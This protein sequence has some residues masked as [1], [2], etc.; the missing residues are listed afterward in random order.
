MRESHP[1]IAFHWK[2]DS[3]VIRIVG[4]SEE[5]GKLRLGAI[6]LHRNGRPITDELVDRAIACYLTTEPR[7]VGI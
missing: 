1:D 4:I 3:S 2:R 6:N 7:P 5:S